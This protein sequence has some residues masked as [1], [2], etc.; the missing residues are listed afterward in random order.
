LAGWV[1]VCRPASAPWCEGA[2]TIWGLTIGATISLVAQIYQIQG[3]AAQFFLTWI[4]LGLPI[5]YLL[6]SSVAASLYCIGATT[7]VGCLTSPRP[8]SLWY[9][10]LLALVL[11]HLAGVWRV[12]RF[13]WRAGLTGWVVALCLCTGTGIALEGALPG[14]WIVAY[15]GLLALMYL[16]GKRWYAGAPT[17]WQR[18]WQTAGAVGLGIVALELTYRWPWTEIQSHWQHPWTGGTAMIAGNLLAA[19]LAIAAIGAVAR[20]LPHFG[21]A[22]LDRMIVGL[23]PVCGVAGYAAE[24]TRK[25]GTLGQAVFNVYLFVLGLGALIAGIRGN[26][27]G[28][29][30]AGLVA[31][32]A[33]IV[34]RFFD[35]ELSFLARGLAFIVIGIGFLATNGVMLRRKDAVAR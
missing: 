22:D 12:N 17:L 9:W 1:L 32:A 10:G 25:L 13:G 6:R 14:M 4:L 33:L 21:W 11:P 34:A 24:V 20:E 7:W 19:G 23:A 28:T 16:A 35:T 15:T 27:L 18:P 2:A 29:V 8:L 26:K 3:D 30:N 31:L 5:V